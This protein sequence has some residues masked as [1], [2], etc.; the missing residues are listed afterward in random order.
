MAI[1]TCDFL[2]ELEA[3]GSIQSADHIRQPAASERARAAGRLA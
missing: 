1:S 3:A 2:Q